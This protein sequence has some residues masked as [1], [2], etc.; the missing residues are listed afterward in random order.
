MEFGCGYVICQKDKLCLKPLGKIGKRIATS[1]QENPLQKISASQADQKV[2][3]KQS[4]GFHPQFILK[5]GGFLLII[6]DFI[7]NNS[8][9]FLF[10]F[11]LSQKI[12]Y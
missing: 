1:S 5:L 3:S 10:S 7:I 9:L 12:F 6:F 8:L 4:F 2:I 11:P